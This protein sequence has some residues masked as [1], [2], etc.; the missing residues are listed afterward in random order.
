[1]PR[2]AERAEVR[3]DDRGVHE[4][5][6]RPLGQEPGQPPAG[7]LAAALGVF[8]GDEGGQ[9]ERLD[10]RDL[11]HHAR[12]E[13]RGDEVL[14][15]DRVPEDCSWV[16]LSGHRLPLGPDDGRTLTGGGLSTRR[17]S[18]NHTNRLVASVG[19]GRMLGDAVSPEGS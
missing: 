4:R 1:L 18:V 11:A 14:V 5:R 10:E 6:R 8:R 13:L 19:R 17:P 9:L 15:L 3:D 2:L 16:A 12:V 7:E